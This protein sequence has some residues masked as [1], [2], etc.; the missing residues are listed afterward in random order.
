VSGDRCSLGGSLDHSVGSLVENRLAVRNRNAGLGLES[1]RDL[2]GLAGGG[3]A[4]LERRSN[5]QAGCGKRKKKAGGTHL[6]G[7]R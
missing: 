1:S 6:A 7:L 5:N 2:W 4:L 3:S